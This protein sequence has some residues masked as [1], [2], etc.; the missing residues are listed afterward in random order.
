M[1]IFL[2]EFLLSVKHVPVFRLFTVVFQGRI[3]RLGPN[4]ETDVVVVKSW[5]KVPCVQTH[6]PSVYILSSR[7]TFTQPLFPIY[8]LVLKRDQVI[9][10]FSLTNV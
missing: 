2:V 10:I 1:S 8:P 3:G 9:F 7:L 5:E 6:V 4:F